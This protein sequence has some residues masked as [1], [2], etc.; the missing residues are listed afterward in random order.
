MSVRAEA[1]KRLA[2]PGWWTLASQSEES[3][4]KPLTPALLNAV[5]RAPGLSYVV[6]G[7]KLEGY[8]AKATFPVERVDVY[9]YDCLALGKPGNAT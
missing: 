7:E 2:D 6:D 9:L 8:V 5:C 1:L 3:A 4:P